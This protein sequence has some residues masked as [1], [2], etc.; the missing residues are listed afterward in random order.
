[1]GEVGYPSCQPYEESH[2]VS[3]TL[4]VS[5]RVRDKL[6]DLSFYLM[7]RLSPQLYHTEVQ[8]AL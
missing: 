7:S 2:N 4:Y 3:Q 6:V 8:L 5:Q 1:M